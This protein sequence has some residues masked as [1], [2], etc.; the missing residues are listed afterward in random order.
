[1]TIYCYRYAWGNNSKRAILKGRHCRV[2]ARLALNS[3]VVEF[4]SGQ[5]EC[6]SRNALRRVEER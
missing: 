2:I 4:E 3:A 5:R 6:I 1:M